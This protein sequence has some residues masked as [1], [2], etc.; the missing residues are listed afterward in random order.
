M[1]LR[2]IIKSYLVYATTIEMECNNVD[3]GL[4]C[5]ITGETLVSEGALAGPAGVAA[6]RV[7]AA[8][9]QPPVGLVVHEE[10]PRL[11][12]AE[13]VIKRMKTSWTFGSSCC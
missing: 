2:Y 3:H 6:E 4:H 10:V 9:V 5:I 13:V 7:L 1:L 8:A 12:T 11:V